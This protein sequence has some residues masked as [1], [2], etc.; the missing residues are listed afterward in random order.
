MKNNVIQL[1]PAGIKTPRYRAQRIMQDLDQDLMLN[2]VNS[3]PGHLARARAKRDRIIE[4]TRRQA[5]AEAR[6]Q[7]DTEAFTVFLGG[8]SVSTILALTVAV[9]LL[10]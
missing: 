7:K 5:E 9:A 4:E 3:H 8:L 1:S 2:M 6:A 10:V